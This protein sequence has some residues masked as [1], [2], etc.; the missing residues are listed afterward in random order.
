MS[1][2]GVVTFIN[3]IPSFSEGTS[4][5]DLILELIHRKPAT[6]NIMDGLKLE[7]Q[8][9][10]SL[11]SVKLT[12]SRRSDHPVLTNLTFSS[13]SGQT[14]ALVG[15][16]GAENSTCI[17]ILERFYDV[18]EGAIE[19]DG[20][21]I[22]SLS[23]Y[24]LRTQMALVGQESTLFSGTIKENMCFGLKDILIEKIMEALE[25]ANALNFVANLPAGLH[26][27]AVQE[28]LDRARQGRTCITI[29]HRLSSIQNSDVI[30]YIDHG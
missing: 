17:S 30:M 23:L 21:D 18:C 14:I 15:P 8:G 16:S 25:L 13:R 7:I 11:K 2:Y 28:A 5:I 19:I 4:A 24:W 9:K 6:G 20:Q 27:K 1:A 3:L 10:I 26:T 29:A 12:Y 22:R